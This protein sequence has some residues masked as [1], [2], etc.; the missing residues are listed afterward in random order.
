MEQ[1][2][3]LHELK[4]MALGNLDRSSVNAMDSRLGAV[5]RLYP[6]LITVVDV[7]AQMVDPPTERVLKTG[8]FILDQAIVEVNQPK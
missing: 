7:V 1:E 6:E 4:E 8:H 5:A 3:T 2:Q